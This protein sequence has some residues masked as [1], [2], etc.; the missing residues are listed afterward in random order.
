M[1][2]RK[3]EGGINVERVCPDRL[4]YLADSEQGSGHT[5]MRPVK[6]RFW[7]ITKHETGQM[8][9]L[10]LNPGGSGQEETL[11]VFSFEEEAETFLRSEAPRTVGWRVRES[12]LGELVLVLLGACASVTRV[13][14]DPLPVEV[15]GEAMVRL[16]SIGRAEFLLGLVDEHEFSASP[17]L[18]NN[19]KTPR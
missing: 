3:R 12:T 17:R 5:I 1:E 8:R 13:A 14:L 19:E 4:C 7:L 15:G 9:V 10:I 6:M 16:L 11:P 2:G 18:H